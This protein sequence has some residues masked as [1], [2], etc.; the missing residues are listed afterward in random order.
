MLDN[1][2]TRVTRELLE[3][4]L[5]AAL[6]AKLTLEINPLTRRLKPRRN[7]NLRLSQLNYCLYILPAVQAAVGV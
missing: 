3:R 6:P 4:Q 1:E 2:Q 7:G 5:A